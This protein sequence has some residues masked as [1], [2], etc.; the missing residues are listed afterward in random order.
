MTMTRSLQIDDLMAKCQ[1]QKETIDG[2][3][4]ANEAAT[5]AAEELR[6]AVDDLEHRL[7][8]AQLA[9]WTAEEAL[10]AIAGTST[11]LEAAARRARESL[12]DLR[13][14]LRE[15]RAVCE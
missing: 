3:M 11:C 8:L 4:A 13:R 7:S 2:L 9:I 10:E 14:V 12:E 5:Q 15:R 6:T 1:G